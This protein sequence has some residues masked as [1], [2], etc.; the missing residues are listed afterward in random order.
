M[1]TS[2]SKKRP[3]A[4]VA[5]GSVTSASGKSLSVHNSRTCPHGSK[6]C[7][8]GAVPF[9]HVKGMATPWFEELCQQ[10]S[11]NIRLGVGRPRLWANR[12]GFVTVVKASKWDV[13]LKA[14]TWEYGNA[15]TC[16]LFTRDLS[17]H[18]PNMLGSCRHGYG[19]AF[20]SAQGFSRLP[21]ECYPAKRQAHFALAFPNGHVPG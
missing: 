19:E 3:T 14:I 10:L 11:R 4:L 20:H 16:F 12:L 15:A 7:E 17:M 9:L 13:F 18:L 5:S 8:L 1:S 2:A 21:F 6:K